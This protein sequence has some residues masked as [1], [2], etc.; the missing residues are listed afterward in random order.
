MVIQ[1]AFALSPNER[2]TFAIFIVGEGGPG[3]RI[4]L[5]IRAILF[6]ASKQREI[7]VYE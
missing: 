1:W 7:E 5:P 3:G 4:W 2:S 6:C